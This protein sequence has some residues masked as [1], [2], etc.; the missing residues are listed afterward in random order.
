MTRRGSAGCDDIALKGKLSP[1]RLVAAAELSP[2]QAND[3]ELFKTT[4]DREMADA[5][6]EKWGE[7]FAELMQH[8]LNDLA[9]GKKRGALQVHACRDAASVGRR[10]RVKRSRDNT[11]VMPRGH[12]WA[13]VG[14][15]KH[16]WSQGI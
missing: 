4:W 6:Q 13:P 14:G 7:L 12:G 15:P 8:I 11:S 3:W 5:Q 16:L 10:A 1:P 2:E 9:A